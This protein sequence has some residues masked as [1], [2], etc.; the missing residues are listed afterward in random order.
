MGLVLEVLWAEV[1]LVVDEEDPPLASLVALMEPVLFVSLD[2]PLGIKSE[3]LEREWI[4]EYIMG[5]FRNEKGGNSVGRSCSVADNPGL[6]RS[7]LVAGEGMSLVP[8]GGG[9]SIWAP[10]PTPVTSFVLCDISIIAGKTRQTSG[11]WI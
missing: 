2:P 11:T 4:L 1:M 9:M 3:M 10:P 6:F 7:S 5:F 8:T